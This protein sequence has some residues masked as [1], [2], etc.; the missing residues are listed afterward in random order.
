ELREV[1][2]GI[3]GVGAE[4]ADSIV[5]YGA[6]QPIFVVDAYTRRIFGRLGLSRPDAGYEELQRLFMDSLPPSVE[7]FQEYHA[8]IVALGKETCR[9][10]PLCDHCPLHRLCS[11][12][13]E[14]S[15]LSAVSPQPLKT[16]SLRAAG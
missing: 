13:A 1:L 12:V 8:L 7:L 11:F 6:R 14:S 3:W 15:K 10:R 4:T 16:G 2:L 5:L 9:P